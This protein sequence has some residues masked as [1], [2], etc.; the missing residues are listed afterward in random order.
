MIQKGDIVKH[1]LSK[2]YFICENAKHER[3]M[4]MNPF[5][6]KVSKDEVPANYF[7]KEF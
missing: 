5:Y 1:L 6:F 3:W 4:N 7:N 2:L